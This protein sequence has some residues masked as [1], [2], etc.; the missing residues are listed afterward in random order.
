MIEG[1]G[2]GTFPFAG[3]FTSV[4]ESTAFAI[5]DAFF[6][7]GGSH[8]MTAPTYGLGEVEVLLGRY[9]SGLPRSAFT[10]STT[11]GYLDTTSKPRVSGRRAAVLTSAK[12]SLKRLGLD[13]V[14]SLVSHTPD[15]ETPLEETAGALQELLEA[16]YA[17]AIGVANVTPAQLRRYA[18]SADISIVHHRL[19]FLNRSIDSEFRSALAEVNATITAFQVIERGLLTSRG[20]AITRPA[21]LRNSKPEFERDRLA[22]VRSIVS[23]PLRD[24]ATRASTTT[25]ELCIGWALSQPEVSAVQVGCTQP[26]DSARLASCSWPLKGEVLHELER[27]YQNTCAEVSAQGNETVRSYLGLDNSEARK[28]NVT[29]LT[30]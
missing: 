24:I 15:P 22:W 10:V 25:E 2:L 29:G 7:D 12:A 16:G 8:I 6:S 27:L 23:G 17:S 30:G 11:C 5:L 19:S 21:D 26:L 9:L 14:D 20:P 13:Y 28:G 4:D 1:V 18:G 3:P